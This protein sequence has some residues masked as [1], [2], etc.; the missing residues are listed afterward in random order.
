MV[1]KERLK[2]HRNSCAKLDV[3]FLLFLGQY[4]SFDL[5]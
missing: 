1:F 4:F 3:F 2:E 5:I